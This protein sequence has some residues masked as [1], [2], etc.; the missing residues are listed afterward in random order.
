MLEMSCRLSLMIVDSIAGPIRAEYEDN[1]RKERVSSIHKLG[2][3]LNNIARK[4]SIPV[5]VT[6]QVLPFRHESCS[7]VD[8]DLFP[9]GHCAN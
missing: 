6:N 2:Y 3:L 8:L 1:S 7:L 4:K 5:I 9:I